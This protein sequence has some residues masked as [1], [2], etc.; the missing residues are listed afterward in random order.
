V[1]EDRTGR[2]FSALSDPTRREV[3]RF[4]SERSAVTATEL[5]ERL[6][7]SRQAVVKHLAAL[8]EAGLVDASKEGREKRYRLTPGGF[9]DAMSWI[10]DV[11]A[12]WDE[13]LKRLRRHLDES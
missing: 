4:L 5:A 1:S 10:A 9:A 6:P 7:I 2:V 13:R 8:S 11:G 12:E 3:M